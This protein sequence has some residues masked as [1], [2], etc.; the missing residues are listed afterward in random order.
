MLHV[1]NNRFAIPDAVLDELANHV[2][3]V[4]GEPINGK[5]KL[6]RV[7]ARSAVF[8]MVAKK[9]KRINYQDNDLA[10]IKGWKVTQ[11][12]EQL[13]Q[14]DLD[15]WLAATKLLGD[16]EGRLTTSFRALLRAMGR[17]AF[18]ADSIKRVRDS[19]LRLNAVVLTVCHG[20]N[21]YIG[22]LLCC[23]IA[24]R[25]VTLH[26]DAA[27]AWLWN[28]VVWLDCATRHALR[29]DLC[30]WLHCYTRS[31]K[32]TKQA[33]CMIAMQELHRLCNSA[34]QQLRFFRHKIAGI[35]TM[36]YYHQVIVQWHVTPQGVLKFA[37]H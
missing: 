1:A 34:Q 12:G 16:T 15:V 36:L 29:G 18:N 32:G 26:I 11:T 37:N 2:T 6:P 3:N 21:S 31:H 20:H 9:G 19:L 27:Q 22:N 14:Y 4:V 30:R 10:A 7:F 8:G 33:P 17:K 28:D 24:E 13:S 35:F 23:A 25:E 5:Y